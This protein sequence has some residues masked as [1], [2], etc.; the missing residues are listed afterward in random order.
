MRERRARRATRAAASVVAVGARGQGADAP[1]GAL[2]GEVMALPKASVEQVGFAPIVR[3]DAARR[4]IELCATSE[5]MDT[6]GTIFDYE[7]SKDAFARWM[8]NVREMHERKAVGQRVGVRFDD[9]AKKVFVTIRISRG[10]QDTWEKVVDGTLRGASIGASNVQWQTKWWPFGGENRLVDVAQRYDLVELSLV[11]NPSNPDALGFMFVRDATPDLALLDRLEEGESDAKDATE[12][13]KGLTAEGAEN[14]ENAEQT[15][16]GRGVSARLHEAARSVLAGCGCAL[17][18]AAMAALNEETGEASEAEEERGSRTDRAET[19]R[20]R[21]A[22]LMRALGVSLRASTQRLA[23]LDAGMRDVQEAMREAL[24]QIGGQVSQ[25]AST[26]AT[27][28][29]STAGELGRR[30]ERLEAQPLPGGPAARPAEK[31]HALHAHVSG[32][33]GQPSAAEQYRALEA[34]A[35]RIGDPQAQIAVAAELIRLQREGYGT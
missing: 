22:A 27:E 35:G 25:A 24:G 2:V 21:E 18:E 34:L 1:A 23:R 33:V 32:S 20:V 16:S 29:A 15:Q 6:Y 12:T 19:G 8:G 11:D 4:E 10:A 5:A 31:T 7:A 3:L 28:M 13:R 26:M 17:C 30:L 14:A 9:E